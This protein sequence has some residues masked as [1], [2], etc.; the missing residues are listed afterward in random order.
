MRR[1]K[2]DG[3]PLLHEALLESQLVVQTAPRTS[4]Q[5]EALEAMRTRLRTELEAEGSSHDWT[6]VTNQIGMLAYTGMNAAMCDELDVEDERRVGR[7]TSE[8][9][10]IHR[11]PLK[12]RA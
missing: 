4:E 12:P 3:T 9:M 10:L 5:H 8:E 6:H 11:G 7:A 2:K 1:R